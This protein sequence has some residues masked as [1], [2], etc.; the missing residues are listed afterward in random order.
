MS[1]FD[2]GHGCAC[3]LYRECEC[4]N[5]IRIG[6]GFDMKQTSVDTVLVW[7]PEEDKVHKIA[8]ALAEVRHDYEYEKTGNL[9]D[10]FFVMA[11]AALKAMQ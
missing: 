4:D 8:K 6:P 10:D 3:G 9:R 11:R 2:Y 7:K 5:K 1:Q